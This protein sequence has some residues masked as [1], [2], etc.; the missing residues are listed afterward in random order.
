M[1]GFRKRITTFLYYSMQNT[2]IISEYETPKPFFYVQ[3]DRSIN[4][5]N[6]GDSA[7]N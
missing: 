2:N 7:L 1:N 5:R 4:R 3:N 6:I